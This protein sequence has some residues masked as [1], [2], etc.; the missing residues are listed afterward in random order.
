MTTLVTLLAI[1]F[2]AWIP[3]SWSTVDLFSPTLH[4][5][6]ENEAFIEDTH[7]RLTLDSILHYIHA[8]P[9]AF[10]PL[11]RNNL[12]YVKSVYWLVIPFK[13]DRRIDSDFLLELQNP[14]VDKLQAYYYDSAGVSPLGPETGDIFPFHQRLYVHRNFVWPL[15]HGEANEFFIILH[16]DKRNTSLNIPLYVWDANSFRSQNTWLI[17]FY[18]VALGMLVLMAL[19]SLGAWAFLRKAVYGWFLARIVTGTLLLMAAEGLA[20][21]LLYP[22][23]TEFNGYF[24]VFING[25]QAV[26]IIRFTQLFLGTKVYAPRLHRFMDILFYVQLALCISLPF[27]IDYYVANSLFWLPAALLLTVAIS[28]F[29][30]LA[31]VMVYRHEKITSVFY[32]A[33]YGITMIAGLFLIMED[34]GWVEKFELNPLFI[35]VLAES[36]ILSVGL[37]YLVKKVY[38]ER[39]ELS[40]RLSRHQK[41]RM[42]AYIEGV[43]KER[44]RIAGELHDDIGSRLGNL[45]RMAGSPQAELEKQIEIISNGVRD[46]SHQLSPLTLHQ[47][48]L[49][50]ILRELILDVQ[51]T[52]NIKFDLQLFD[53]PDELP[54]AT[55][56]NLFR[57]TQEAI[58]NT[59]KHSRA[60]QAD[61]QLFGYEKEIVLSYEDDGQGFD[62]VTLTRGIGLKNLKARVESLNGSL[63]LTSSPGN[64][65]QMMISVPR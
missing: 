24:R 41:E 56:V 36:L 42:L 2:A 49:N 30:I 11:T 5:P 26:V 54:E 37:T 6:L 57:I 44:V 59:L 43:E 3:A 47:K 8:K 39:N 32:L 55:V 48:G 1:S 18:G 25:L 38:D 22:E 45:R 35:A 4:M 7:N 14:Q 9:A 62:P 23:W 28:V 58:N 27:F 61:I 20:F 29:R 46:L 17:I 16:I 33:A 50:H 40:L 53:I 12:G 21:Q 19:Y 31:A 64:G 34:F 52:T 10:R 65:M 63:E 15:P 51:P 60:S 13:Q